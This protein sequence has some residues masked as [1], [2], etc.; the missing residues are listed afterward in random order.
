MLLS[1][2]LFNL[3]AKQL[4]FLF[5]P[6][7]QRPKSDQNIPNHCTT[8]KFGN[9][10]RA[11]IVFHQSNS[12]LPN[13]TSLHLVSF[14]CKQSPLKKFYM[15][16]N[17]TDSGFSHNS[18]SF[19][20]FPRIKLAFSYLRLNP[21]ATT[22]CFWSHISHTEG[23]V[24]IGKESS[25]ILSFPLVNV[26]SPIRDRSISFVADYWRADRVSVCFSL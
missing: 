26:S 25:M 8:W 2:P 21:I 1:A 12:I 7:K 13:Q 22:T 3:H 16:P 9:F 18:P 6:W 4:I 24:Q 15:L 19:W 5:L 20:L 14:P 23:K 10:S 11:W 17:A